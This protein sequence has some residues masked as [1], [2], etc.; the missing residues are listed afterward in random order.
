[1]SDQFTAARDDVEGT[2]TRYGERL[3]LVEGRTPFA[4]ESLPNACVA[5]RVN[6]EL[7]QEVASHMLTRAGHF[8]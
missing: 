2:H 4:A 5:V 6:E 3:G 7:F 1:M 8:R